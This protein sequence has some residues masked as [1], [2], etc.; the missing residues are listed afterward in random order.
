MGVYGP[1]PGPGVA[2]EL[3]DERAKQRAVERG[4]AP[5]PRMACPACLGRRWILDQHV[6]KCCATCGG[7]ATVEVPL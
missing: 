5:R 2:K 3:A 6:A 4:P 1:L 7:R